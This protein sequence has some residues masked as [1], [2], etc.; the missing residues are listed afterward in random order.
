V[1]T[2]GTAGTVRSAQ[3]VRAAGKVRAVRAAG[4]VRAVRA[5]KVVRAALVVARV[6][7]NY[8]EVGDVVKVKAKV[9]TLERVSLVT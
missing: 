1:R 8:L 3:T 6:F 9:E 2:I 5:V 7:T 4:K